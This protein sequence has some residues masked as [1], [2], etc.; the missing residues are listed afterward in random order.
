MIASTACGGEFDHT[1]LGGIESP[2]VGGEPASEEE[3][4]ATVALFDSAGPFCTGTL[5]APTVIATAAHCLFSASGQQLSVSDFTVVAG[6]FEPS[7]GDGEE[8]DVSLAVPH[9]SF[10][11]GGGPG[12]LGNDYDVAVVVLD[13]TVS[14]QSP[15]EIVNTALFDSSVG[16][17]DDIII[18][19]YGF[20]DESA[21]DAT[22][23]GVLY[24]AETPFNTRTEH[25][26]STGGPG[27]PD[28]CGGD[29]GGP[30]YVA[31][32]GTLYL[33]GATSRSLVPGEP[34]C[35]RGA[36]NTFL[37]R[38]V[39]WLADNSDGAFVPTAQPEVHT[40]SPQSEDDEG[41]SVVAPGSARS[42]R[43]LVFTL[44]AAP[45]ALARRRSRPG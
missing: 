12:A 26:F 30:G 37:P 42:S 24:R 13:Q 32:D 34:P 40:S 5:I 29:S 19:G 3:L 33:V 43:W 21:A 10:A 1:A 8:H 44:L 45:L 41:C 23:Y 22:Q 14:A 2:I 7:V 18:T 9:A 27:D 17:G 25:E 16:L 4:H 15:I 31:I 36:I 20:R 28:S 38:W 39:D 11:G 35:G 6:A